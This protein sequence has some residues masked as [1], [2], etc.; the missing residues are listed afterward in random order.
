MS[1]HSSLDFASLIFYLEWKIQ[2][3]IINLFV[4]FPIFL[5]IWIKWLKCVRLIFNKEKSQLYKKLSWGLSMFAIYFKR[6][7]RQ[8]KKFKRC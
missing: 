2:L 7:S 5:I 6:M 8:L 3:A 1:G 4:S